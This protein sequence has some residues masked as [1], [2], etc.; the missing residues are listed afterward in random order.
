M[1]DQGMAA[2]MMLGKALRYSLELQAAE[3]EC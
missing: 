3:N 1:R 2:K